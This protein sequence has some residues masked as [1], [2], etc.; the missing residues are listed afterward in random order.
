MRRFF[1]L[2]NR[3]FE[4]TLLRHSSRK[5][6]K[7]RPVITISRERGSGG[8]PIAYLLAK[9]LGRP[10]Q[11]YHK[12][13]VDEIARETAFD[14]DEVRKL[15]ESSSSIVKEILNSVF[16][17]KMLTL[18]AYYKHLIHIIANIA[19]KGNAIIIGRGANFLLP[20]ALKI[21]IISTMPSR[22]N[23]MV[24]YEH[25]TAKEAKKQVE[26]NDQERNTFTQS[27]FQHDQRKAFHY[28]LVIRTGENIS[29]EDAADMIVDLAKKKFNI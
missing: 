27:L 5:N 1:E 14:P 23:A 29:V 19:S 3:S 21:R 9:K 12:D 18:N 13:I 4:E 6:N 16:G 8:K 17:K 28:D 25:I 7:A 26:D 20:H 2:I 22:I 24:K 11:V 15:D 10:W